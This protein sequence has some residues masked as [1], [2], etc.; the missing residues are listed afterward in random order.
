MDYRIFFVLL[1]TQILMSLTPGPAVLCVTSQ[2]LSRGA[3]KSIWA[4]LGILTGNGLYFVLSGTGV[5]A[6]L[7]ASYGV[8]SLVRWIGAAYLVWMG[9]TAMFGKSSTIAR[10]SESDDGAGAVRIFLKGLIVQLSNPKAL[11]FFTALLPQFLDPHRN[12]LFQLLIIAVV[13]MSCDLV[14][15][16]GYA[17]LAGR[18][19]HLGDDPRFRRISNVAA[20]SMLLTAGLVTARLH[21]N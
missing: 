20:G 18:V 11:V 21:R 15:L 5:G 9:L 10:K 13:N 2:A 8:F 7:L 12:L 16:V 3:A 19:S 4:S 1:L 14:A 6:L 17:V